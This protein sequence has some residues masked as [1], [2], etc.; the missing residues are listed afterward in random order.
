MIAK[1]AGILVR[2]IVLV[3]Q[4]KVLLQ[5]AVD[6]VEGQKVATMGILLYLFP[7]HYSAGSR[8]P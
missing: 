4:P 2:E 3:I 1:P 6:M 8:G 7:K 5:L